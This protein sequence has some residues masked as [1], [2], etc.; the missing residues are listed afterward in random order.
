MRAK[1]DF[2]REKNDL[3]EECMKIEPNFVPPKDYRPPKKSVK[4]YIP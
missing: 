4:I 3:I 1:D 2:K